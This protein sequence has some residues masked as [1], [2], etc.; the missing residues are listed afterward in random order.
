MPGGGIPPRTPPRPWTEPSNTC[1]ESRPDPDLRELTDE[2]GGGYFEL[3]STDDLSSTFARVAYELHSQ[4]LLG[5]TATDL[6]G[7]VHALDV[8]VKR[9]GVTVRARKS[10]L[11]ASE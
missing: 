4:Y 9:A 10:Y 1:R 2:G 11:A 6:D 3:R 8:R 5:F 7:R